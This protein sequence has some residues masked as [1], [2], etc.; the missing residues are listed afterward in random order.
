MLSMRLDADSALPVRGK[1]RQFIVRHLPG[2]TG[3]RSYLTVRLF[4]RLSVRPSVRLFVRPSV[5]PFVCCQSCEHDTLKANEPNL[6][7]IGA[8]SPRG[9]I[10]KV[11]LYGSGGQRS[12]SHEAKIGQTREHSIWTIRLCCKLAPM[13]HSDGHKTINFGGY[14]VKGQCHR[15]PKSD[16]EAWQRRHSL[17]TWVDLVFYFIFYYLIVVS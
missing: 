4:I 2:Q 3:G 14:R 6:I 17:P 15:S 5:R 13:V 10:W 7:P 1:F 8:S 11:H 9:K 16:L 12:R